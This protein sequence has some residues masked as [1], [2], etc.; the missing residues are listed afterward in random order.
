MS[1]GNNECEHAFKIDC[2]KKIGTKMTVSVLEYWDSISL[3]WCAVRTTAK[4]CWHRTHLKCL[5]TTKSIKRWRDKARQTAENVY[6]RD[7]ERR[8]VW[9]RSNVASVSRTATKSATLSV[10]WPQQCLDQLK[11]T[12][13]WRKVPMSTIKTGHPWSATPRPPRNSHRAGRT[14]GADLRDARREIGKRR[15]K[16]SESWSSDVTS[17][18]QRHRHA[19][20]QGGWYYRNHPTNSHD[21]L[22]KIK[23]ATESAA[24]DDELCGVGGWFDQ[25]HPLCSHRC[26]PPPPFFFFSFFLSLQGNGIA[27]RPGTTRLIC[28][29]GLT[30]K[31]C[32]CEL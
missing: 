3:L 25:L 31:P 16:A 20:V 26:S 30:K 1:S 24:D 28:D 29:H 10:R 14:V 18:G 27:F 32:A 19:H 5:S 6:E 4:D 15:T 7:T 11:T 12:S 13:A 9:T 23:T 22:G 2:G 8:R 21:G 17:Y